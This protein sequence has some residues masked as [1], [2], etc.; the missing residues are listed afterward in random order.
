MFNG[1]NFKDFQVEMWSLPFYKSTNELF[2]KTI[3]YLIIIFSC[4]I[5]WGVVTVFPHTKITVTLIL[6]ML[7]CCTIE[8][9]CFNI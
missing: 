4:F 2:C 8:T 5:L 9:E 7:W 3:C 1:A 6:F